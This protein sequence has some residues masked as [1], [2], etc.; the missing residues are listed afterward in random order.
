MCVAVKSNI[1]AV[2]DRFI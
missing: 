1:S 2:R